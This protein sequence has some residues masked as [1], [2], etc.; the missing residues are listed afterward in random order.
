MDEISTD[1][2]SMT[3]GKPGGLSPDRMSAAVEEMENLDRNAL[4]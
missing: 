1:E 4:V 3:F 2:E